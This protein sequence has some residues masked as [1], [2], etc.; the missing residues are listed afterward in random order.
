MY[1]VSR[2]RN[3]TQPPSD[4]AHLQQHHTTFPLSST[5]HRNTPIVHTQYVLCITGMRHRERR[6]EGIKSLVGKREREDL[7]PSP[8]SPPPLTLFPKPTSLVKPPA[9]SSLRE[10][11]KE[12]RKKTKCFL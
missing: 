10:R 5:Q 3:P 11:R 6:L 7:A 4:P 8:F 1:D 12:G 9:P 2:P